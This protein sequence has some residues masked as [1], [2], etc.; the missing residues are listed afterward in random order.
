MGR[1]VQATLCF[2]IQDEQVL[3]GYKKRGLGES[4]YN[5]FGGKV[6]PG[7]TIEQAAV[8]EIFEEATI[9]TQVE[10]L[11]KMADLTFYFPAKPDW[12]QQVHVYVTWN[13]EGCPTETEEMRPSWFPFD[14]LPFDQM[15]QDDIHWLPLVLQGK[16]VTAT[17][18]FEDDNESI[19]RM[20]VQT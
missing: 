1:M 7:E 4:K 14:R 16:H 17:F 2:I 10:N 15:W 9:R 5:G 8:R 13:W 3:L 18:W 19:H 12:D 20:D 11:R 6:K